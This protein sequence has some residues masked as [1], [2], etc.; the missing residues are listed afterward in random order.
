MLIIKENHL[1]PKNKYVS[2]Y[3]YIKNAI[4]FKRKIFIL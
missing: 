1:M 2:M 3:K 4:I